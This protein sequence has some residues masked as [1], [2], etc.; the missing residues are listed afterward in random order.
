MD[1]LLAPHLVS[2]GRGELEAGR[3]RRRRRRRVGQEGGMVLGDGM[4]VIG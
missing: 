2:M 4:L 3:R 1:G